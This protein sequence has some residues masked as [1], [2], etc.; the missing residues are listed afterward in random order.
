MRGTIQW[1]TIRWCRHTPNVKLN[2]YPKCKQSHWDNHDFLHILWSSSIKSL[3]P[4]TWPHSGLL[5]L[6]QCPSWVDSLHLD[7]VPPPKKAQAFVSDTSHICRTF[8]V[9]ESL[10]G[11][12][13]FLPGSKYQHACIIYEFM[14]LKLLG[15]LYIKGARSD[16]W[17]CFRTQILYQ[18]SNC[19]LYKTLKCICKCI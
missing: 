2:S 19:L 1:Q 5:G 16:S 3:H 10:R 6:K 17:Q 8:L 14:I 4:W 11:S 9:P 15:R 18:K 13:F 7:I 12:L